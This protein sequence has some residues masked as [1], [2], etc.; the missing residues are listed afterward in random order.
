MNTSFRVDDSYNMRLAQLG[1][2]VVAMGHRG[3]SPMRGKFYLV[4]GMENCGIIL[5]QMIS[6]PSSNW[7][8]DTLI[9]ISLRLVFS[10]T[11][12]EDSCQL[13]H[14]VLIR[15]FT[16]QP[17][18]LREIMIIIFLTEDGPRY[19]MGLRKLPRR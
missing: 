7:Q 19:I 13:Q 18:R 9:L 1:F 8:I 12:E 2:I 14:F 3:G 4:T 10:D 6:M 16:L 17:C 15:I 5:W 11:P